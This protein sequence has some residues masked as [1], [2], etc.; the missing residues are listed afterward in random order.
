MS[1]YSISLPDLIARA[2]ANTATHPTYTYEENVT[3]RDYVFAMAQFE[4]ASW[5]PW[6]V[7]L[8]VLQYV[9][10]ADGM[11]VGEDEGYDGD[12]EDF[13]EEVVQE[14]VVQ[15]EECCGFLH[16]RDFCRF[17]PD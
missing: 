10:M 6:E 1:T 3:I 17:F 15:E 5:T 8:Y 4:V 13:E 14:K 12:E 2:A 7:F 11:G 9:M 16:C